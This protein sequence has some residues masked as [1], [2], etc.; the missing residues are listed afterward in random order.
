MDR[1]DIDTFDS[2]R[3]FIGRKEQIIHL[4]KSSEI[5]VWNGTWTEGNFK[6][7]WRSYADFLYWTSLKIILGVRDPHPA[8]GRQLRRRYGFILNPDNEIEI[9][10]NYIKFHIPY[11]YMNGTEI[12]RTNLFTS[13]VITNRELKYRGSEQFDWATLRNDLKRDVIS[14]IPGV[15][16]IVRN[17]DRNFGN[18]YQFDCDIE[19]KMIQKKP[20][21]LL[22]R[23]FYKQK[24]GKE[25]KKNTKGRKNCK[26]RKSKK[27][28]LK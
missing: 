26:H 28:V 12:A 23:R 19:F 20:P 9:K 7:R 2:I 8:I 10:I 11:F 4:V 22:S 27:K 14:P 15:R 1:L 21:L 6:K 5:T 17:F 3:E 24:K 25:S 16:A 13:S 18:H